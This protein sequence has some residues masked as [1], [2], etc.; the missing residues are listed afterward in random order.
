M[1][2]LSEKQAERQQRGAAKRAAATRQAEA[3][4]PSE[5]EEVEMEFTE[6]TGPISTSSSPDYSPTRE[7]YSVVEAGPARPGSNQD[8]VITPALTSPKAAE[9]DAATT[10]NAPNPSSEQGGGNSS[11]GKDSNTPGEE[12]QPT[13]P[14]PHSNR[15]SGSSAATIRTIV[16]DQREHTLIQ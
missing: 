6:P 11:S 9:L 7:T 1:E 5:H 14:H 16:Q 15:G 10:A 8:A 3:N 2:K 4:Q 13:V 12:T